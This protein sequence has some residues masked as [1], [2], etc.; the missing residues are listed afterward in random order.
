MEEA[1][2][3]DWTAE[4]EESMEPTGTLFL[5]TVY[6]MIVFGMWGTMY[7]LLLSR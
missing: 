2:E 7:W 5:V 6:V 3:E 4:R 1:R